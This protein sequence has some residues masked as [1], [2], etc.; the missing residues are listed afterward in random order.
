MKTKDL[1]CHHETRMR[2]TMKQS[3][4]VNM[5]RSISRALGLGSAAFLSVLAS[6]CGVHDGVG[7][8]QVF[9]NEPTSSRERTTLKDDAYSIK[10][11]VVLPNG[12][13][14][15]LS[16]PAP[17]ME[18]A[19]EGEELGDKND[20]DSPVGQSDDKSSFSQKGQNVRIDVDEQGEE[21]SLLL[22][23]E[24]GWANGWTLTT[25]A[26]RACAK[27]ENAGDLL[28]RP[29][30]YVHPP[31]SDNVFN[32]ANAPG[33][34]MFHG[35][36]MT[37]GV[38]SCDGIV[39]AQEILLCTA[40][41]LAEIA[42]SVGP[43]E[44]EIDYTGFGDEGASEEPNWID[45]ESA[46]LLIP[47]Q[48]T[49]DRFIARDMA[50]NVL[51]QL[52]VAEWYTPTRKPLE[53]PSGGTYETCGDVYV[54][55]AKGNISGTD[56][57]NNMWDQDGWPPNLMPGT[58]NFVEIGRSRI[59]RKLNILGSSARLMKKLVVGGVADDL[60]TA[61]S[62]R[63]KLGDPAKGLQRFWGHRQIAE[64]IEPYDKRAFGAHYYGSVQ[65]ALQTLNARL[66]IGQLFDA[67]KPVMWD[68]DELT[69]RD[70]PSCGGGWTAPNFF[71]TFQPNTR[72]YR[73]ALE[74]L[75]P[76]RS[77]GQALASRLVE[78]LGLVGEL[79][80]DF[81]PDALRDA[82]VEAVLLRLDGGDSDIA[83]GKPEEVSAVVKQLR[84]E[85]FVFGVARS[86]ALLGLYGEAGVT[87]LDSEDSGY[88]PKI[89]ALGLEQVDGG[90]PVDEI[91]N[92]NSMR[93]VLAHRPNAQCYLG[94]DT[95]A[96]LT[97]DMGPV[98]AMQGVF[99]WGQAVARRISMLAAELPALGQEAQSAELMKAE[100]VEWAGRALV[101]A[102]S[103][104]TES[105]YEKIVF[106][107]LGVDS[108]NFGLGPDEFAARL[109]V[110]T[111]AASECLTGHRSRCEGIVA[112][113]QTLPIDVR[114]QVT[115]GA[116]GLVYELEVSDF[117]LLEGGNGV[118]VIL[119][120]KDGV[121][122]VV[123]GSLMP[124]N[125]EAI[126]SFAFEND[127]VF[128]VI[129]PL[130]E[131]LHEAIFSGRSVLQD[132][133]ACF[134]SAT[135]GLPEAY[136]IE[137]M[138]RDQFVPLANDLSNDDDS[139]T[140]NSW[141]YYLEKAHLAALK[142]DEL[143]RDL[144][145]EGIDDA[146]RQEEAAE[147]FS[148]L[149]GVFPVEESIYVEDGIAKVE[150]GFD[151]ISQCVN[152]DKY[153]V[154]FLRRDPFKGDVAAMKDSMCE[155][156]HGSFAE[157]YPFCS[158]AND[159]ITVAQLGLSSS[160]PTPMT[161]PDPRLACEGIVKAS[162]LNFS[163][164]KRDYDHGGMQKV[165]RQ[166]FAS[167]EGLQF[168][169]RSLKF[170]SSGLGHKEFGVFTNTGRA[171][172]GTDKGTV[173]DESRVLAD[174]WPACEP[175]CSSFGL[176]VK[177]AF[178]PGFSSSAT[179]AESLQR[180]YFYLGALAGIIPEGSFKLAVPA[181][182]LPTAS[183]DYLRVP[184]VA[185]Y[186]HGIFT[187]QGGSEYTYNGTFPEIDVMKDWGLDDVA[188]TSG[189][190][191]TWSRHIGSTPPWRTG[192]QELLDDRGY[193]IREVFNTEL[194]FANDEAEEEMP[195]RHIQLKMQDWSN[196][197]DGS[198][199]YGPLT[200][201]LLKLGA[202]PPA[203]VVIAN[204]FESTV[205]KN[206][207][208]A[209]VEV[210]DDSTVS[211]LGQVQSLGI[212]YS[213]RAVCRNMPF[214]AGF[215]TY[216]PRTLLAEPQ[217][218][219]PEEGIPL[220][221]VGDTQSGI[222]ATYFAQI[223]SEDGWF[224]PWDVYEG[225][226][227]PLSTSDWSAAF[228]KDRVTYTDC[229]TNHPLFG[230]VE[231]NNWSVRED[232]TTDTY[233][234][235]KEYAVFAN[236]RYAPE[237]CPPEERAELFL[238]R[239]IVNDCQ[240]SDAMAQALMLSCLAQNF[241]PSAEKQLVPP[242][243][244][245]A[246]D[247]FLFEAWLRRTEVAIHEIA[248]MQFLVGVPQKALANFSDEEFS[249]SNIGTGA[250]GEV[251]F[252]L[253]D[254]LRAIEQGF[255]DVSEGFGTMANM[256]QGARLGIE[257]V[258]LSNQQTVLSLTGQKLNVDRE[259]A[260]L[261][262]TKSWVA[263]KWAANLVTRTHAAASTGGSAGTTLSG[264]SY[265]PW[266]PLASGLG[267]GVNIAAA[268]AEWMA[269]SQIELARRK[270]DAGYYGE[271]SDNYT[272][273]IHAAEAAAVN[274]ELQQISNLKLETTTARQQI[275]EAVRVIY[276]SGEASTRFLNEL[277][278]VTSDAR[279]AL[280]KYAGAEFVQTETGK[281]PRELGSV[282]RRLYD[283]KLQRYQ[284][285]LQ[286]AK[287]AAYLARL[288]I[289]QKL[290]VRLSD[291]DASVG[292]IE[293]PSFWADDVCSLTG[294]DYKA[295]A[296]AMAD[297]G[298]PTEETELIDAFADQYV[299]DYVDQLDEFV[300]YYNL[301]N[302]FAS[303]SDTAVISLKDHTQDLNQ[304]CNELNRNILVHTEDLTDRLTDF[305]DN[306]G[307][308]KRTNC[309]DTQ[310]LVVD[311]GFR[312][313]A[314]GEFGE[315]HLLQVDGA[316]LLAPLNYG[317]YSTISLAPASESELVFRGPPGWLY[318]NV[319][320]QGGKEYALSYWDAVV[321][322]S[323]DLS[324]DYQVAVFDEVGEFVALEFPSAKSTGD[325]Q[326]TW[327]ERR[328]VNFYAPQHGL[329]RVGFGKLELEDPDASRL[330]IANVQLEE[331][332]STSYSGNREKRSAVAE[333]CRGRTS[334]EF[335][336]GFDYRCDGDLC[337]YASR[338]P[339]TIDEEVLAAAS[340]VTATGFAAGNYNYRLADIALNV[341]GTGVLD[342]SASSP[343]CFSDGYL[344]YT[345]EHHTGSVPISSQD[346]S[347][348][349]FDFRTGVIRGGKALATERV[350]SMPLSSADQAL[351]ESPAFRKVE[352]RGRP[353]SGSY[354]L[355]IWDQA[356]LDWDQVEDIQLLVD[357]SYWSAV[358]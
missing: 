119:S 321:A 192:T 76:P 106:S 211:L 140:E 232:C 91:G 303:S 132:E 255:S 126:S 19:A 275:K 144:L 331:G 358:E 268:S 64:I 227:D 237:A 73:A 46:K 209:D 93:E 343:S 122:G 155:D 190:S 236:E 74:R 173:A 136:C 100:I 8:R 116:E 319:E 220:E 84:E 244:E 342:C 252:D 259:L 347:N 312:S 54:D 114:R 47:P 87:M 68:Y 269:E 71:S 318:Q 344:G 299:G 198:C 260:F 329:Y 35:L 65:H 128:D 283:I 107:V 134:S 210:Q 243:I 157:N 290:G 14:Y 59:A 163:G 99:P 171:I 26:A 271:M 124:A 44:W 178:G 272:R 199:K 222:F 250:Q 174:I 215:Y 300:D 20:I 111:P 298:A 228:W 240:A 113:G 36:G 357:Y 322:D 94:R 38:D 7:G 219:V 282:F 287:R 22:D 63:A 135:V 80:P 181:Y 28:G 146:V 313:V 6:A 51:G 4:K 101:A 254:S 11:F 184:L 295:L 41:K 314:E 256:V 127:V 288:A 103:T 98:A 292:P 149:C 23:V 120:S 333:P 281:V 195:R 308:W 138:R 53:R 33:F 48:R 353:L 354:R 253:E 137:G 191:V 224:R 304:S 339:I 230:N 274:E 151:S 117:A 97:A 188:G 55:A 86:D 109:S 110:V 112:E 264:G 150:P 235:T 142:A 217:P 177:R 165:L 266:A 349:C 291:L 345:L 42:E 241:R 153:D 317:G 251:M 30:M 139:S 39:R 309:E 286:A 323:A 324:A 233:S 336:E 182:P 52:A 265:T 270:T 297:D 104:K 225:L 79:A 350:L 161:F 3:N 352:L 129:S 279:V 258:E 289:E 24:R 18:L 201:N 45:L 231:D 338:F 131:E 123:L 186:G 133:S 70:R 293:P 346:G 316:D 180:G 40:D 197:F 13:K 88:S 2:T 148:R 221:F 263:M 125:L 17:G 242:P 15:P 164:F 330:A 102:E 143:G 249:H 62:K 206:G 81:A 348:T 27:G 327:G 257:G 159:E 9:K 320:L 261:D 60:A 332:D 326:S 226:S 105:G 238:E 75:H 58:G 285:A 325:A 301:E 239:E 50:V 212:G 170:E 118:H 302:P 214:S 82:I 194:G 61:E 315:D 141:R 328:V 29:K 115:G 351:I 185:L 193:L 341:V 21:D 66:E 229:T 294:I 310:C 200:D 340:G 95:V 89:A 179:G 172:L 96:D 246:D 208:W 34:F 248:G 247:I 121:P 10:S 202:S 280:A 108:S 152:P 205:H 69:F 1:A 77:S 147:E 5:K 49:A 154:V 306:P 85:D 145:I 311:G 32:K 183:D 307:S 90:L 92:R 175:D 355:R 267:A 167:F 356:E 12:D 83:L 334:Q 262:A 335:R 31:F 223:E 337:F 169:I 78:R 160:S 187:N 25:L 277:S 278:R 72:L 196:Q 203:G 207:L 245:D 130:R 162:G 176:M 284:E 156:G 16:F 37:T 213:E 216:I 189:Q 56:Y 168:A 234:G 158:K 67:G 204:Y 43:V 276:D 218:L 296:M 305:S 57:P 166:P 273:Q